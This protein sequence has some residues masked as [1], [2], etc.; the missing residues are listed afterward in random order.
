MGEG[1]T[2]VII[3]IMCLAL[4]DRIAR[5]NVLPSLLETSIED[6][7]LTMGSSIFNRPIHVY[8]FRRDIVSQ[9]NDIQFQRILSNLKHC[10]TNQGIIISTPDHWLSFQNSS[11]LSKSKTLFNSIIQWSNNNLFNILDEC[12]ELLSTKYQLIF[13]YGNKRDLDEGVNRWTIIESVFDKLKTLLDNEQ[14]PPSDI[15]IAKK[16]IPCSFPI[17]TIRNEEAGKQLLNKLLVLLYPS[18]Q[19]A[20]IN[21]QFIL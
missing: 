4:K 2:S 19:S 5:I 17:I 12:D 16:E 8:P 7:L 21:Q 10:K 13:P 3:P 20:R 18:G 9:L 15:E 14:F 1:K 11:M 6:M